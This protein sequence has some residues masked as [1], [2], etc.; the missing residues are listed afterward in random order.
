[1][2]EAYVQGSVSVVCVCVHAQHLETVKDTGRKDEK[3]VAA[4]VFPLTVNIM[5]LLSRIPFRKQNTATVP[6]TAQTTSLRSIRIHC[7]F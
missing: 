6:I 1:M 7:F 5:P 3:G 4:A 2:W